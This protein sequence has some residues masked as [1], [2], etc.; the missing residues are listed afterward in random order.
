MSIFV[1]LTGNIGSGKSTVANILQ[2]EGVPVI[3]SDEVVHKLYAEDEE[4]KKFLIEEFGSLEKKEIAK[5]IFGKEPEKIAKR[6]LL[7]SKVHPKVEEFLQKWVK[8][9]S[10]Y[11]I[12]VNDVPLL[13][14]AN[15]QKRF[16]K[17][18]FIAID[19]G[20]QLSRIRKRN[21]EM[22]IKEIQNRINSQMYQNDKKALSDYII[23][24]N[25]D[26]KTLEKEVKKVVNSIQNISKI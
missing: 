17:I 25:S 8:D 21:P 16:K 20:L 13:F 14:E 24:N 10:Q 23:Y 19:E 7:E 11:E 15:L 3:N 9:N 26:L 22:S 2:K 5:Q 1:G 4:L 6:K 18:I 12:L